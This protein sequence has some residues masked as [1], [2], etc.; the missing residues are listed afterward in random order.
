M[1]GLRDKR[2]FVGVNKKQA[3]EFKRNRGLLLGAVLVVG[4]IVVITFLS[5]YATAYD[6]SE[7][8]AMMSQGATHMVGKGGTTPYICYG[9]QLAFAQSLIVAHT[10]GND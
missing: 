10:L 3:K 5:V 9:P 1:S 4:I 8:P 6:S 2:G 7:E